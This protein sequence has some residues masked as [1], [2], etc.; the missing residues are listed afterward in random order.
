[1]ENKLYG[2]LC[3]TREPLEP[4]IYSPKLAYS[5][6]LAYTEDGI[7]YRELNHN[8]GVLFAKASELANGALSAKSL[9]N[10][11]LFSMA[12]G[13]FG[14]VAIRTEA[15][16]SPDQQSKG[17][18]LLFTSPDLLQYREIGLLNLV[19]GRH[20]QD[21][22]C[23]YDHASRRY[24]L[25]WR[26][27]DDRYYQCEMAD[28]THPGDASEPRL[29]EAFTLSSMPV[30]IEG[31]VPR[32]VI[33][34]SRSVAQRLIHKLTV[35]VH[36]RNELPERVAVSSAEQLQAVKVT[37]IY[38]D[39]TTAVKPVE[40]DAA[41]IDW[42]R[43]GAYRISGSIRQD[44]FAFPIAMNRADPC[45][46]QWEGTY[47]FVATNDADGNHSI[48][49]RE[50]DSISGLV[51][52]EETKILDTEMHDHLKRFLWAPELHGIGGDLYIFLAGS[53]GEFG[54]IQSHV[55]RLKKGGNP[56]AA[57]DWDT[58]VRVVRRD[59]SPLCLTGI[60]LDMTV[61]ERKGRLYVLWA[62]REL[63]PHDLGSWIYIAEADVREPWKLK[64]APVL[65]SKPD[66]GWANNQTFVEE[67]PFALT[68]DRNIFVTISGALVD[69]T[70]CVGLL[71]ADSDA[72][73]LDPNSWTKGNYPLLASGSVPGEYGPGHNSYVKDEDGTIWSVYHARPGIG[74]PRCSGLRRVHFDIDGE[75][76]L[77]LTE[78]QDLNP[79]LA[80][81]FLNVLV[82]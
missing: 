22:M 9:K 2:I 36:V 10:P 3:Y 72:N 64:S 54:D 63:V 40:W 43:P 27:E 11:Y 38:S 1:M 45:I 20:V 81:V 35:P 30:G 58:P 4:Q 65:L 59:G 80:S 15:D 47:Y 33:H 24:I 66:Y 56:T 34:V 19:S 74:Q 39:G 23:E 8:S 16:G 77:G 44:R 42:S 48:S 61:L 71:S 53:S 55:M 26:E 69:A 7:R 70:Y 46:A 62:Q 17:S 28:V 37:A 13:N 76:M 21:V 79:E 67:G 25:R 50:A 5:M 78:E 75:P 51:A 52:A 82:P 29:C 68:T 6:H 14:V 49:I 18:V 41:G 32:N 31:V 57:G 60:T 73:L 12:D